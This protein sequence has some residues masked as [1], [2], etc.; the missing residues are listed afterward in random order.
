MNWKK[1]LIM[2]YLAVSYGWF[3]YFMAK[4]RGVPADPFFF[5]FE[6]KMIIW[7]FPIKKEQPTVYSNK[8]KVSSQ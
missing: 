8:A 1:I 3:R 6:K 5:T 4:S 7:A 2:I